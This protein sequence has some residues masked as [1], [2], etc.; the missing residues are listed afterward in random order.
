VVGEEKKEQ[1]GRDR[2]L[3]LPESEVK[4]FVSPTRIETKDKLLCRKGK[5]T[6]REKREGK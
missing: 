5:T 4:G 2:V 1:G 6:K 3:A